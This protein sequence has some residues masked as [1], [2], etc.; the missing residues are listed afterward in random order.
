MIGLKGL[1]DKNDTY[2]L[3]FIITQAY[4]VLFYHLI[5]FLECLLKVIETMSKTRIS[6][7]SK[8]IHSQSSL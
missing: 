6:G 5:G 4:I 3:A 7:R 1:S 2:A 8:A